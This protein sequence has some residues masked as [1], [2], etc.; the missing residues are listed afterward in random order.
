MN[1]V[2]LVLDDE[3]PI[4]RLLELF[5]TEQGY[6]VRTES[7]AEQGLRRIERESPD[8]VL[9]D[10]CLGSLDGIAVAGYAQQRC[11]NAVVIMMTAYPSIPTAVESMRRGAYDYLAKPL[12]LDRLL[13]TVRRG[14]DDRERRLR[15]AWD[16]V[17]ALNRAATAAASS[18]ADQ[19]QLAPIVD[20]ALRATGGRGG[21]IVLCDEHGRNLRPAVLRG[22]AGKELAAKLARCSDLASV[23]HSSL[24]VWRGSAPAAVPI[25]T[26]DRVLGC[27]LVDGISGGEAETH[28]GL[29]S[30]LAVLAAMALEA[31]QLHLG[32]KEDALGAIHALANA[33]EAKDP[34]T[35]GH[36]DRV[37]LYCVSLAREMGWSDDVIADLRTA[38]LLHDIGKI[39]IPE[40]ILR[41]PG[42]LSPEERAIMEQHPVIGDKILAPLPQLVRPR[43]WIFQHHERWDGKGYPRGI[44]GEEIL[45]EARALI[46]AEVF[47]ALVSKRSYKDAWSLEQVMTFLEENSG[48]HFA[49]DTTAAFLA[50]LRREG[51][52]F[53]HRARAIE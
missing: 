8:V 38:S 11:P 14:L 33:V 49:P 48:K 51:E 22:E 20:E 13:D 1:P 34:H 21:C 39:G 19:P 16:M 36:A 2:V 5:L 28:R 43:S 44:A 42:A 15:G 32:R 12:E 17:P 26:R 7:S 46:V 52:A 6:H 24:E 35:Q 10:L 4:C 37:A 18:H 29:L 31:H 50:I 53:L 47:D 25:V 45:P 41:K 40:E 3:P 30:I 23:L 27:L 9:T